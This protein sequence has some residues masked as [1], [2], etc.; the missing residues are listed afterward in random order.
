M[1]AT[2]DLPQ[3]MIP[4]PTSTR[5]TPPAWLRAAMALWLGGLA[6]AP[7][8]PIGGEPAAIEPGLAARTDLLFYLA[9]NTTNW[10]PLLGT[11]TSLD[12]DVT[13][14]TEGFDGT[15]MNVFLKQGTTGI[16]DNDFPYVQGGKIPGMCAHQAYG[17]GG[18]PPPGEGWSARYMWNGAGELYLYAYTQS[19]TGWG[20]HI[21]NDFN[22]RR[23]QLL[24]GRWHCIEQYIKLNDVGSANGKVYTW[25]DGNQVM[26]EETMEIVTAVGT[27]EKLEWNRE[28]GSMFQCFYGGASSDWASPRDTWMRFDNVVFAKNPIGPRSGT[29][30]CTQPVIQPPGGSYT[31]QVLV[32]VSADAGDTIRYT[33]NGLEPTYYSQAYTGPVRV[34][35]SCTFKA[36]AFN[37]AKPYS[38]VAASATYTITNPESLVAQTP[39]TPSD[40]AYVR[41]SGEFNYGNINYGTE[42]TMALRNGSY[43]YERRILVKFPLSAIQNPASATLRLYFGT[44]ASTATPVVVWEMP[45]AG[46]T[47][48]SVTWNNR[49]REGDVIGARNQVSAIGWQ[50]WDVSNIVTAA[51]AR[52]DTEIAFTAVA[53]DDTGSSLSVNSRENS[54][55]K[56]QL[57]I[58]TY[59]QDNAAPTW[60]AG[61]PKV[62]SAT[63]NSFTVRGSLNEAGTIHYVVLAA[64]SAVPSVA[65]V[66]AGQNAAGTAAFKSGSFAVAAATEGSAT[67][68]G[69]AAQ[70]AYDV[71]FAAQDNGSPPNVQSAVATVN[72][73]TSAVTTGLIIHEPF[74]YTVGANNPDPDAGVNSGNGLPAS[75]TGGS[76]SGTSTGLRGNWGTTLDVAAGLSYPGL[77]TSGGSG[78]PN[79]ATW[80]TDLNVYQS[81]ATDPHLG[82]RVASSNTGKFGID[83]GSL[84]FSVLAKT[85]SATAQ[86]CRFKVAG[87]TNMF[88]ENTASTWT[89]NFN[90]AGALPST[91]A[92]TVG[93]TALLVWKIDFVAG[94]GDVFSLWVN[95]TPGGTLGT[96]NATYTTAADWGGFNNLNLRP[97]V[98]GAMTIDE[99]RMGT[100]LEAVMPTATPPA[101]NFASWA[102]D[103]S[104]T[105]GISGDSD[106][107]GIPNGIEYALQTNPSGHDSNPGVMTGNLLSFT[108]RADAVSN[109]DV[110]YLIETSTT[111]AAGSWTTATPNVN[112]GSTISY[113]LPD[114]EERLFARLRV[115]IAE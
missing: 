32:T 67:V 109:G 58:R 9:Y 10:S 115:A 44:V 72:A 98:S 59:Q 37:D 107:D 112:D 42:T 17:S 94:V 105:G 53:L 102:S 83:G 20:T 78:K 74:N 41:D 54:S 86:A 84:W 47:N 88:I 43:G 21:M 52:G 31:N 4:F 5:K 13:Q 89:L 25:M 71:H 56:P 14:T 2:T 92:M 22:G 39:V 38:P 19:N 81:M 113:T 36:R 79:N 70:T 95:P 101:E 8:A 96:P 100:T 61:W 114:N 50:E 55:N 73:T 66:I 6:V 104:I 7:A 91:G 65:Q 28:F 46:W 35:K 64:G 69:L 80:G 51:I 1:T 108:K 68:S 75:N 77:L 27:G 26:K 110:T 49:P 30:V 24:P 16:Q 85:T 93:E 103:N 63:Q 34:S 87:N 97:A 99:F 18:N 48:T 33:T 40:D 57:V 60:S 76:P 11:G 90:A 62:D 3:R 106:Q 111:L 12:P 23:A 29:G 45:A 82:Q 15:G